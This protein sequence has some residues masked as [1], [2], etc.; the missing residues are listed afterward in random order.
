METKVIQC[1]TCGKE[2]EVH[3]KST[4]VYC[5][6]S[7]KNKDPELRKSSNEARKKT[8]EKKYGGHP[9]SVSSIQNK[10]SQSMKKKFGVSHALQNN[11]LKEKVKS[12]KKKKYG[13][14]NYNNHGKGIKTRLD[15]YGEIFVN[16]RKSIL[17]KTLLKTKWTGI[18]ILDDIKTCNLASRI[19]VKCKKCGREWKVPLAN[20]RIPSC[21]CNFVEKRV[22]SEHLNLLNFIKSNLP[23]DTE[24]LVNDRS[25]LKNL[26]LDIYIPSLDL[27]FE[28]NGNYWHSDQIVSKNYHLNKTKRTVMKGIKLIHVLESDWL[29]KQELVKSMVL[30]QISKTPNKMYARKCVISQVKPKEKKE[31]LE[32]NHLHGNSN[33]SIN[34]GLFYEGKLVSLATFRKPRFDKRFDYELL[35]FA[36]L[37]YTSV[38]GGFSK[39]LKFFTENYKFK[40]LLSYADRD[41][42]IG[43]LYRINNFQ[44]IEFTP[45]NYFYVKGN[46]IFPRQVF[47]KHKLKSILENFDENLTEYQNMTN[48]SYLRIYNTG[49][50]KF[51]YKKPL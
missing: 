3:I 2:K 9:M 17:E 35:R 6:R 14:E 23:S 30:N 8:W 16:K 44:F 37:R 46:N 29:S 25:V 26:E 51:V 32:E 42:S 24:V 7:C 20:N 13:N 19:S 40:T 22:S 10:H 15:K 33:S 49:N 31:F 38:I 5:S 21:T 27:A 45:P 48:N 1:K 12:T 41:W 28:F 47:Q 36:N 18:E 50:L 39:I 43:S 4:R 34:I 11:S